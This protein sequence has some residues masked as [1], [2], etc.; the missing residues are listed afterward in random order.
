MPGVGVATVARILTEVVGKDFKT[1]GYLASYA[2]IAP[3][4]RRS[5]SSI[6]GESANCGSNKRLKSAMFN[7]AFASLHHQ[8]S[9]AYYDKKPAAN[10]THKQP[11]IVLTRR[12][13]DT[14]YAMLADGTLYQELNN[15][16]SRKN[17][18]FAA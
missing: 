13:L 4:T 17:H 12:R 18:N 5:V 15:P 16:R 2:G 8:P 6:R 10:K 9:R 1:H 3:T 11:I 14:L 7:S